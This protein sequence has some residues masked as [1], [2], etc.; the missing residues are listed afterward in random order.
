MKRHIAILSTAFYGESDTPAD[1]PYNNPS[2][3]VEKR[4]EDLLLLEPGQI[5][6]VPITLK[7]DAFAYFY[8]LKKQWLVVWCRGLSKFG[9]GLHP[10]TS[11]NKESGRKSNVNGMNRGKTCRNT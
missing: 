11:L 10:P 3:T 4:I 6:A 7:R 5:K 2:L 9:W 1:A 8:P